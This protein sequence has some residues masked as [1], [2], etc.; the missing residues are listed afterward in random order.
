MSHLSSSIKKQAAYWLLHQNSKQDRHDNYLIIMLMAEQ[1][2]IL[3]WLYRNIT[4]R[5]FRYVIIL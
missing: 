4:F 5:T 3:T 2:E 1:E